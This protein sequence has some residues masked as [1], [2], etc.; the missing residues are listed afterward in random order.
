[1]PCCLGLDEICREIQNEITISLKGGGAARLRLHSPDPA[2]VRH[3]HVAAA[4]ATNTHTRS[5][6]NTPLSSRVHQEHSG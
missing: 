3:T 4:R 2:L 6:G 5:D 1:M